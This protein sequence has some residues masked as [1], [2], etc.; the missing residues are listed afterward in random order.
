MLI[1]EDFGE[2]H[3]YQ[4]IC[5]VHPRIVSSLDPKKFTLHVTDPKSL[6]SIPK[7]CFVDIRLIQAEHFDVPVLCSEVLDPLAEVECYPIGVV[8][9][10]AIPF[11]DPTSVMEICSRPEAVNIIRKAVDLYKEAFGD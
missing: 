11:K 2:V 4:E 3:I 7:I 10:I 6:I 5:P 8:K 1:L 9:M